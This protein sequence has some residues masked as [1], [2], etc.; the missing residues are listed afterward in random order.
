MSELE[1]DL[2]Q[3][4][5]DAGLPLA[6]QQHPVALPS[7]RPAYLDLGYRRGSRGPREPAAPPPAR[8]GVTRTSFSDNSWQEA[9]LF[10]AL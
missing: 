5:S 2:Q 10:V 9:T 7:G 4:L 8:L 3:A 6:V 1:L